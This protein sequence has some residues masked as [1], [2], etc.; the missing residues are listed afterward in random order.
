M[1]ADSQQTPLTVAQNGTDITVSLPARAPDP[2]ASVLVLET[3]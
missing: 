3:K 1:L 2:I